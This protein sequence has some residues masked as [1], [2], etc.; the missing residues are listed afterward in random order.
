MFEEAGSY[1]LDSP[2]NV[3]F[4]TTRVGSSAC[5]LSTSAVV[6]LTS[7]N[8]D[9]QRPLIVVITLGGPLL[10]LGHLLLDPPTLEKV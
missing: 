3:T 8:M 2:L 5:S 4:T 1:S 6:T 7:S 9:A 10:S